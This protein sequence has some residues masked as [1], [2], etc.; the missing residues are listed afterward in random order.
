MIP[1][2]QSEDQALIKRLA[3]L[4]D[5]TR[6]LAETRDFGKHTK[7]RR[8]LE[9]LRR[10]LAQP[11]GLAAVQVRA[12]ALDEAG[13]FQGTDW[14]SP[15]ILIPALAGTGLRNGGADTVV[16]E[17]VSELRMLA[18]ASGDYVHP[19][20]TAEEARQFVSQ[21]LATN[22]SMLFT[23]PSEADRVR[24]GRSA[25]LVRD[26]F[27]YL[28]EQIG[29]ESVLDKLVEEIWR[30]LR[31][32]P[33]QVDQ[34]Q[35]MITQVAVYREDPSIDIGSSGQGIDRLISEPVRDDRGQ[36]GGPGHRRLPVPARGDGQ[37]RAAVRGDRVRQ[38]DAR[39]RARLALP[40]CPAAVP[41]HRERRPARR[42]ARPVRHRAELPA[43]LPQAGAR[44]DRRGGA[45]ADRP[46][47]LRPRAACWT[48]GSSTSR[49][50][51]RA[52][53]AS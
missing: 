46:V 36:P 32:R 2:A 19:T 22:L 21:V 31:Q 40:R 34:V 25:Q 20:V 45:P 29:Y 18:I 44:P 33:I 39:H 27:T 17:T 41:A 47:H 48:A 51:S 16:M 11:G 15:D 53:G 6:A 10:T 37:R 14:A 43:A 13:L 9:A 23:P 52:C 24:Q 26:L 8:M 1:S 30:I 49:P 50:S 5:A 4:D 28:A 7:I 35:A 3:S 12:Q 38:G 42:G